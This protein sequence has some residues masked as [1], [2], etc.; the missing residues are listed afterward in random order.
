VT[1]SKDLLFLYARGSVISTVYKNDL[2]QP[3][4][5]TSAKFASRTCAAP[6]ARRATRRPGRDGYCRC[7]KT[8]YIGV[9][10]HPR[11]TIIFSAAGLPS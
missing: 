8:A 11:R 10:F 5:F 9:T 6:L 2:P 4:F 7:R 1:E 3:A